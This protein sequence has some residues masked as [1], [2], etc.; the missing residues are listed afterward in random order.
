MSTYL[1]VREHLAREVSFGLA[2]NVLHYASTFFYQPD[3]GR[4]LVNRLN[5]C[6]SFEEVKTHLHDFVEKNFPSK[7]ANVISFILDEEKTEN[8]VWRHNNLS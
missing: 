8:Q 7:M 4:E 1:S 3:P 2:D 6:Q 5:T